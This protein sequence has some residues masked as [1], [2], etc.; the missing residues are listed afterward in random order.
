MLLDLTC[1]LCCS[2]DAKLGIPSPDGS[3]I[4]VVQTGRVDIYDTPTATQVR[5]KPMLVMTT[6]A[7]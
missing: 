7:V 4:A 5:C 1:V 3:R 6:V 2:V